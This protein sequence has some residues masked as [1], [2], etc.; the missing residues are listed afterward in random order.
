MV[1]ECQLADYGPVRGTMVIRPYGYAL[2]EG[3]QVG[4]R[5]AQREAPPPLPMQPWEGAGQHGRSLASWNFRPVAPQPLRRCPLLNRPPPTPP[6]PPQSHLDK[7]FKETGHQNAYFP[8]LIPYSFLQKEADHVEG[9]AP[10]LALVTQGGRARGPAK[11][12]PEGGWLSNPLSCPPVHA[13][14]PRTN[15]W[16]PLWPT[17]PSHPGGGKELEEPLV[18]RPTSETIVNHMFAQVGRRPPGA[19]CHAAQHISPAPTQPS[20]VLLRNP[21]RPTAKGVAVGA[22]L[23]APFHLLP[24]PRPLRPALPAVGAELPRPAAAHQPVGQRAPLGD[25]HPPLCAHPRV[26]LAGEDPPPCTLV[27]ARHRLGVPAI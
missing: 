5:A 21:K 15:G 20:D 18:V 7:A 17:H 26:P 22:T 16:F 11:G 10:E 6:W 19:A 2:W 9:F 27:Y 24:W 25:A 4:G 14:C 8:Q 1:R 13:T 3:V 23:P 12:G